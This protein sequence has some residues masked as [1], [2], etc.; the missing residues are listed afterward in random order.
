MRALQLVLG[1]HARNFSNRANK[2]L[3]CCQCIS[4]VE[5]NANL[6]DH[7]KACLGFTA[8]YVW[9]KKRC[10][11]AYRWRVYIQKS[12]VGCAAEDKSCPAHLQMHCCWQSRRDSKTHRQKSRV[13]ALEG[14]PRD[15][16][17]KTG[18]AQDPAACGTALAALPAPAGGTRHHAIMLIRFDD[19]LAK[20]KGGF[21]VEV[22]WNCRFSMYVFFHMWISSAKRKTDPPSRCCCRLG[23]SMAESRDDPRRSWHL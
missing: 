5:Q 12:T 7:D 16:F 11:Q 14:F 20:K 3:G 2:L 22:G 23:S 17:K 1:P 10:V 21:M 4:I 19:L 9:I 18:E 8:W 13:K 15:F 6:L